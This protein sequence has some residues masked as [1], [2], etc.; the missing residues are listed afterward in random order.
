MTSIVDRVTVHDV[1]NSAGYEPPNRNGFVSCPLHAERSA[2]FHVVG[3]GSGWR[4]FGCGARGGVLD[5]VVALGVA[6]DRAGAARWLE[7]VRP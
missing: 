4:C 3:D 1:L 6:R 5:L 2:S 7:G